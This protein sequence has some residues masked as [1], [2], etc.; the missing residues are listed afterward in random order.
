MGTMVYSLKTLNYGNYGILLI[1]GNA[2]LLPSTVVPL[3]AGSM[4]VTVIMVLAG[5]DASDQ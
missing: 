2:G 3:T 4:P 5:S 1:M